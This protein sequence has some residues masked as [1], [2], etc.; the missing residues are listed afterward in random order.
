MRTTEKSGVANAM[1]LQ[2]HIRRTQLYIAQRIQNVT[3]I[4]S[5]PGLEANMLGAFLSRLKW[6]ARISTLALGKVKAGSDLLQG[7][8]Q[9]IYAPDHLC[10]DQT[11]SVL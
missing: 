3:C 6:Q 5:S 11:R 9:S 7:T 1:P 10:L 4:P 2:L 8:M